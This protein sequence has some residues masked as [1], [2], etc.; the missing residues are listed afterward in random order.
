MKTTFAIIA[1]A[2]A[3]T[4]SIP[5]AV[6]AQE[7]VNRMDDAQLR[8]ALERHYE[9]AVTL[10]GNPDVVRADDPRFIWANEARTQCGIALGYL[11]G[12]TRNADSIA[13]CTFAHARMTGS[14]YPS[15]PPIMSAPGTQR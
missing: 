9:T 10:A 11:A 7:D 5:A 12:N 4:G 6:F 14:T 3:A 2:I 15:A 8:S 1:T 13:K